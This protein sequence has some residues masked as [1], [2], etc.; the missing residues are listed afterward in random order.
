MK[1]QSCTHDDI[2]FHLF[3]GQANSFVDTAY[4]GNKDAALQAGL[5]ARGHS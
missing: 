4:G 2:I 5:I 3:K 1:C